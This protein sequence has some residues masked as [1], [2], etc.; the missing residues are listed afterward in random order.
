MNNVSGEAEKLV[1][2]EEWN[3]KWSGIFEHYQNDTRHAYY[4]NAM[5]HRKEKK[6]LELAAGSFR[7]IAFLNRSGLDGY[8]MDFSTD[9]VTLAQCY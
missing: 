2:S 5:R 4:I 1:T 6:I 8:G 9:A 7:D 3:K